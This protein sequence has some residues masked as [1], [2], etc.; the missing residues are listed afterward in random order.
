MAHMFKVSSH[1]G[2]SVS[3][4]AFSPRA[5]EQGLL[6]VSSW[7]TTLRLYDV[8]ANASKATYM[9]DAPL[10]DCCFD[11]SG[12]HAYTAGLDHK[13]HSLDLEGGGRRSVL[14][15][16]DAHSKGISS[17]T[18]SSAHSLLFSGSWDGDICTFD[19]RTPN[20][21][22][23]R[24]S[25]NEGQIYSLSTS[26]STL[27]A[28]TASKKLLLFDVRYMSAPMEQ[29]PSPLKS[30]LRVVRMHPDGQS[31]VCGSIEGR[32]ALEYVDTASVELQK[33]KYT[34]KCHRTSDTN[35]VTPVNAVAYHPIKGTFA[36]GGSDGSV[37]VWDGARRKRQ[38]HVPA[39]PQP[40]AA[41][42]FNSDGS[43]LAIASSH[44]FEG[45]E[46]GNR[47]ANDIYVRIMD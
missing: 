8:G 12:G 21:P 44:T 36:T 5:N 10:L 42:A 22:P 23:A 35:M 31:F 33:K 41:L 30:Q 16:R 38:L 43:A 29:R 24:L 1:P 17:L 11:A 28:A 39:L 45:S 26:G 2:E 9:F 13:V 32:C 46:A 47:A 3:Q 14:G 37:C 6:L 4:L 19:R 20:V 18:F 34:F 15:G 25:P 27:V 40:V 7:D